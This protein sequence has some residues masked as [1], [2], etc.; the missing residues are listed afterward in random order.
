[1]RSWGPGLAH[2]ILGASRQELLL[3]S[4]NPAHNDNVH[5]LIYLSSTWVESVNLYFM[6]LHHSPTT[7]DSHQSGVHVWGSAPSAFANIPAGGNLTCDLDFTSGWALCE[8]LW[9]RLRAH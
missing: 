8:H 9:Q 6:Y 2:L 1:M 4:P 3:H 7:P 5:T